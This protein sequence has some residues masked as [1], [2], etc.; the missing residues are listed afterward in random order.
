MDTSGSMRGFPIDKSKAVMA[1]AIS[2]MRPADTFNVITFAG[3]T[4]VLWDKPRPATEANRAEARALVE[5]QQGGGGTEMMRAINAALVQTPVA[6]PVPLTPRMLANLPADNRP[7]DLVVG[8]ERLHVMTGEGVFRIPVGEDVS[9]M[10]R[11]ADVELPTV[12]RPEGVVLRL[13]GRWRTEDGR[14]VFVVDRVEPDTEKQT[15]PLRIVL[16]LTDG[17]VS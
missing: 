6:G 2:A 15:K 9:V 13:G 11:L 17:Y 8:Y 1:R 14:R 3:S 7:V 16:F 5:Q 12:L 4:R 10:L